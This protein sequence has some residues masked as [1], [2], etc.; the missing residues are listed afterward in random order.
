MKSIRINLIITLL[1]GLI[2]LFGAASSFLY[3]YSRSAF[4]NQFDAS[5]ETKLKSL[6]GMIEA[7]I[8][9][10]DVVVDVEFSEHP[11]S[12]F[13]PS[14]DAEYYQIWRGTDTVIARSTSLN[15]KDLTR[16]DAG[17]EAPGILD[18][19]LPDG[20]NGRA[21]AI[22]FAPSP[23][24][25]KELPGF[26]AEVPENLFFMVLAR[27]REGLDNTLITLLIGYVMMGLLLVP[28][29]IMI[30]RWSVGRGLRPLEHIA[31]ETAGIESSNLAYRFSMVGLP[32]ELVPIGG[33]L[34]E[35]LGRLESAFNRERR[36]NADIAHE[37]RTPIAELRTLAE[38][39]LKKVSGP[40]YYDGSK[41][42]FKDALD[43][44]IQ[45]E[46]LVKT[47][48][49]LVRCENGRQTVEKESMDLSGVIRATCRPFQ[50]TAK[51]RNISFEIMMPE[52]AMIHSD[53]IIL[54]ALLGNLFSNAV[55]HT[56][57]GRSIRCEVKA[58]D[59]GFRFSLRNTSD[60]LLPDDLDHVFEPLWKKDPSRTDTE[61]NG[62][63][64]SL[65]AAYA[66]LLDLK[67]VPSLPEPN[68]FEISFLIASS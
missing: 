55:I 2:I 40:D 62:L 24:P 22:R 57:D 54:S 26:D 41:S 63:G 9:D 39:A 28:G 1:V 56:P 65:V 49:A 20:R 44:S 67:I 48:L 43:I 3:F 68:L 34:N 17:K 66:G 14:A 6:V 61:S 47:L 16:F 5:L 31:G 13:Q 18:I 4:I 35:L 27:S 21:A 10:G 32:D 38:V 37:L 53:N 11:L 12:E 42:C 58:Q 50:E 46:K 29:I 59:S 60:H 33:R 36:F 19:L 23:E 30:V 15:G 45:M 8:L 7:E 64:L 25:G 52:Q 51:I